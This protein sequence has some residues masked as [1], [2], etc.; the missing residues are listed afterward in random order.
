MQSI[1]IRLMVLSR[2][3]LYHNETLQPELCR[4]KHHPKGSNTFTTLKMPYFEWLIPTWS[5]YPTRRR[6]KPKFWMDKIESSAKRLRLMDIPGCPNFFCV[7]KKKNTETWRPLARW[8]KNQ[9]CHEPFLREIYTHSYY[10]YIYIRKYDVN[11]YMYI[12]I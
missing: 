2:N 4:G 9:T 1:T 5:D 11:M 10:I 8:K 6:H 3:V 12:Y 7:N